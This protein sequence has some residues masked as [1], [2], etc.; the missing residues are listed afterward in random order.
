MLRELLG[1]FVDRNA[2]GICWNCTFMTWIGTTIVSAIFGFCVTITGLFAK[3]F[4]NIFQYVNAWE[5]FVIGVTAYLVVKAFTE[6]G[7]VVFG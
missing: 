5:M 1:S 6:I 3:Y 2:E 4:L 7:D